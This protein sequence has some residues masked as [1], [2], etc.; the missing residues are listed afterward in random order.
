VTAEFCFVQRTFI[1]LLPRITAPAPV[2]PNTLRL[3]T[4]DTR[5]LVPVLIVIVA[6]I[7]IAALLVTRKRKTQHLKE[8]F[9]PEYDRALK[10]RG[11]PKLAEAELAERERRVHS[12]SIHSISAG[13][14]EKYTEEWSAV[15]R[16]FVDEPALAVNEADNLVNRVMSSRGYPMADFE[17]RAADVSVSHPQVVQNYRAARD[18]VARHGRGESSTEDL[19]RAMVHYRALFD[20][21]LESPRT[22]N[23][24]TPVEV[25]YERAS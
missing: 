17:Q 21:L 6:V 25:P 3:S 16:R 4:M 1:R 23:T 7:V 24:T 22:E 2:H 18:I 14:R 5:I 15:Q 12:L 20:E 9:G 13:A 19:R 11:D 10:E 8:H